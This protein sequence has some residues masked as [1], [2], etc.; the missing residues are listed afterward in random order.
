MAEQLKN[1]PRLAL[2]WEMQ[3]VTVRAT[4]LEDIYQG[5]VCVFDI[6]ADGDAPD[7]GRPITAL[8]TIDGDTGLNYVRRKGQSSLQELTWTSGL[9]GAFEAGEFV[10][11]TTSGAFG[12]ILAVDNSEPGSMIV[13][14]S[15]LGGS[16]AGNEPTL[17]DDNEEITGQTSGADVAADT[18]VGISGDTLNYSDGSIGPA[19]VQSGIYCLAP[20]PDYTEQNIPS[21]SNTPRFYDVVVR[22]GEEADFIV[23]GIGQIQCGGAVAQHEWC[24]VST[25]DFPL[26]DDMVVTAGVPQPALAKALNAAASNFTTVWCLFDGLYGFGTTG[27][28][29]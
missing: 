25:A 3:N 5:D 16:E 10:V 17:F 24:I 9:T 26:A 14:R 8:P 19:R 20:V 18:M 6:Y 23:Q 28:G 15:Y 22:E 1:V 11:G 29:Y 27:T 21:A 12:K 4:A 13:L 7:L 2:L